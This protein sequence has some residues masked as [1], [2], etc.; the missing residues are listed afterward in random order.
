MK[1]QRYDIDTG[2][3]GNG[4]SPVKNEWG[5]WVLNMRLKRLRKRG[6]NDEEMYGMRTRI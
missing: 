3:Y 5:D 1:L 4:Y 2:E 6:M